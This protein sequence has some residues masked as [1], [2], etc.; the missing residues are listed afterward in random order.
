[1]Q[2]KHIRTILILC[3]FTL[4][5]LSCKETK[6]SVASSVNS[7]NS[8]QS[9]AL[10]PVP[11][12]LIYELYEKVD[13]IDYYFRNTNFSV[14]Q[15]EKQ[16]TQAFISTLSPG[17]AKIQ[18]DTCKSPLRLTY[19]SEGNILLETEMYMTPNCQYVEYLINNQKTYRSSYS[20]DGYKFL[21]NL[22]QQASNVRR[23]E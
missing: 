18:N 7:V 21:V 10:P 6:D 14:S 4:L 23:P 16:A 8:G 5:L 1:M 17:V 19:L 3:T 20:E 2:Y 11:E 22:F 9:A 13:H 15:D 12:E